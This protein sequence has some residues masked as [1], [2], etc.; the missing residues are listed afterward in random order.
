[1][2]PPAGVFRFSVSPADRPRSAGWRAERH[3]AASRSD[4]SVP[5]THSPPPSRARSPR[6]FAAEQASRTP[7]AHAARFAS[8]CGRRLAD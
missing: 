6:P 3:G 7:A 5:R 1:M 2:T 8:V 4:R